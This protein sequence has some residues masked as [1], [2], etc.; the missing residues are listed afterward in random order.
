ML[1][2]FMPYKLRLV[3]QGHLHFY[4]SI[5]VYDRVHFITGGAVSAR[6]WDTDPQDPLQEGFV[7]LRTKGDDVDWEYVEYSWTSPGN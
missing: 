1:D 3:L 5:S 2:L 7:L 6:W 4:E